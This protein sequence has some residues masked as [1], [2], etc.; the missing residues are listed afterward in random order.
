MSKTSKFSK[1]R[2]K[3]KKATI[4]YHGSARRRNL[5]DEK[6]MHKHSFLWLYGQ[7]SK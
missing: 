5:L 3:T 2:R 6:K 1:N 4:R 7:K